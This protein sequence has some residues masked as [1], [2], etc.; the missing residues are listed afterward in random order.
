MDVS[1][2]KPGAAFHGMEF[3]LRQ[4]PGARVLR[5]VHPDAQRIEE[6]RHDWA[7]VGLFTMGSYREHYDGGEVL[8]TGPSAAFHPPGRAHADV[9][10][11]DGLETLTIEFDPAWLRLQGFAT[12][13]DRSYVWKGGA[14]GAAS[15]R[16]AN[17]L[18]SPKAGERAIGRA[19]TQFLQVAFA[20][21]T[22][23]TPQWLARVEERGLTDTASIARQLE[24]HPA[25][26]A[27]AYRSA[28]GEGIAEAARRR[29]VEAAAGMLR[30]TAMP[31]AEV[32]LA[33]GFC[34]QGH[35]NRCFRAVLGRSPLMVRR[36]LE[37]R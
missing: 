15:R 16:L 10:G 12:P 22:P 4:M 23:W 13:L 35:M 24:L 18:T 25:Y 8:L 27:R 32:A 33:A 2:V 7:Y 19:T 28:T 31:L 1:K 36:E 20:A 11:S 5:V 21:E 14:V 34:D 29:R 30:R 37:S 9:V 6:H 3:E 17:V 26:L